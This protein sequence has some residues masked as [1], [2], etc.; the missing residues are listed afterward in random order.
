MSEDEKRETLGL[1]FLWLLMAALCVGEVVGHISHYFHQAA[2]STNPDST[3]T[4]PNPP[5]RLPGHFTRVL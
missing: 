5:P 2:P 4:E 3:R 1:L